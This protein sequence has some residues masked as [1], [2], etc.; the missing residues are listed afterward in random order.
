MARR[1]ATEESKTTI[2]ETDNYYLND[3]PIWMYNTPW[4]VPKSYRYYS[5]GVTPGFKSL[6]RRAL[7]FNAFHLEK[8]VHYPGY[9]HFLGVYPQPAFSRT[10][11]REIKQDSYRLFHSVS[12][13]HLGESQDIAAARLAKQFNS[14]KTN[15][16][17]MFHERKKTADLIA[18]NAERIARAALAL[19]RL[20]FPAAYRALN[21]DFNIAARELSTYR[22]LAISRARTKRE[23]DKAGDL[24]AKSWLEL[25]YGWQPML[26]D[27]YGAA[28]VLSES[29]RPEAE[30]KYA[31]K[32]SGTLTTSAPYLFTSWGFYN[33]NVGEF[34]RRTT[35]KL[36]AIYSPDA[37]AKAWLH[38]TGITNPALV[39]WDAVPFSFVVD[40]F[41][42]VSAYLERLRAYSGF[43][44][45]SVAR[46]RFTRYSIMAKGQGYR[47][48]FEYGGKWTENW[49]AAYGE[50]GI[51]YDRDSLTRP[52]EVPLTF[53]DPV[54]VSHATSALALAHQLIGGFIS[55]RR[56]GVL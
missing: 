35:T 28:E 53:R 37:D 1:P 51:V 49:D 8:S 26:A 32:S 13:S 44:F 43:E 15:L 25:K 36:L 2:R 33:E 34:T 17:L 31:A 30:R 23:A 54:S 9:A 10:Y 14:V 11:R 29:F 5:G 41:L 48:G 40:W 50:D 22:K 19:K 16:L 27:I 55:N 38:E 20:N 45:V 46:V 56:S 18:K 12:R 52:P 42:P 4:S 3:A 21:L 6:H 39:L 47:F 7:P 24:L